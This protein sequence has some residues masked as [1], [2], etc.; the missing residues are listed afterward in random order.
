M[1]QITVSKKNSGFYDEMTKN[2]NPHYVPT[3]ALRNV[4]LNRLRAGKI[5]AG[6]KLLA[7]VLND[8]KKISEFYTKNIEAINKEIKRKT[9]VR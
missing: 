8:K 7:A 3:D 6:K 1:N 4:S 9:N 5:Y 2:Y